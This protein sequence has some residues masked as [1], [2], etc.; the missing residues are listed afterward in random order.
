MILRIHPKNNC[1]ETLL[2]DK[3]VMSTVKGK[4]IGLIG[5]G[6]IAKATAKL[7]RAFGMKVLAVRRS[8]GKGTGDGL[9]DEVVGFEDRLS[10]FA[11]A[12]FVV[13]V[14]PGTSETLNFC[15]EKEF[16]AMK[17]TGVFINIGRG[18]TVD[19]A[20]LCKALDAKKIVGAA[21]DVFH[22]EPLPESSPL[23]KRENVLITAHN[24]D[25]TEDYAEQ[26]WR[27][28]QE[29]YNA[30]RSGKTMVTPVQKELGY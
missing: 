12:D 10:V 6:D 20:A 30:A 14:L 8:P 5:F 27:V 1:K 23:W 19:E 11:S 15:G 28:W 24:A 4:T 18:V 26:G 7:A 21:L 22:T 2:R 29:N 16:D 3:F 9:A 25:F 13:S 17:R